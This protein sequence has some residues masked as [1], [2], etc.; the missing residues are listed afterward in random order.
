MNILTPTQIKELLNKHNIIPKKGFGQNF[1]INKGVLVK[2]I[3]SANLKKSDT[4]LEVGPGLGTLTKEL[5]TKVKE[6]IAVEKDW[7]MVGILKEELK[8]IPNITIIQDDILKMSPEKLPK[9]Y[10]VVA[11]LPYYIS[12]AFIRRFLEDM[13]NKPTSMTLLLQKEVAERITASTPRMHLISVAVQAY[14]KATIVG[15]IRP[16]SFWPAPKVNSSIVHLKLYNTKLPKHFFKVVKAG[17]LHPRRQLI[18]NLKEGLDLT[19]EK[20]SLW[21]DKSNINIKQRAETLSIED[22]INLSEKYTINK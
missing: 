11:N 4:V 17:F 9:N 20:V 19:S 6:V 12:A 7:N 21:L 3:E 1:L 16:G 18:N 13:E 5:A 10:K 2:I 8:D 22:W 14:A 15:N